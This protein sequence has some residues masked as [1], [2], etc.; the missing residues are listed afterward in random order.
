LLGDGGEGGAFFLGF[1]DAERLAIDE[2]D[3]VGGAAV[4][5]HFPDGDAAGCVEIE[6]AN[7][8]N[9]P[10]RGAQLSVDLNAGELFRGIR[11]VPF[12]FGRLLHHEIALD[13]ILLPV[14]VPTKR[15]KSGKLRTRWS[16]SVRGE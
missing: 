15:A 5:L 2:E 8:L 10:T 13:Y 3:V 9:G 4:G 12:G 1:D 14:R 16:A 6:V 7:A 11:H